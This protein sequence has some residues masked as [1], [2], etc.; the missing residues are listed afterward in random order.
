[1]LILC[2]LCCCSPTIDAQTGI[3]TD[4]VGYRPAD[5]K[6]AFV[7]GAH[8]ATFQVIG[9]GSD[10][11][12]YKGTMRPVGMTDESTG[13]YVFTLDFSELKAPGEYRILLPGQQLKS[14]VFRIGLDVYEPV[15]NAALESFYY[16]RCGMEVNNGTMWQHPGCHLKAAAFFENSSLQ[17]DVS[18]GW[19][20]AGDYGKYVATASLSAAF[21]LYAYE[22]QPGKF[23]DRQLKIPEAGNGV[24]DIL[25]EARW[26]LQWLLKMQDDKGGVYHKVSAKNWTGEHL[27]QDDQDVQYIFSVS[28]TATGSFAAVT[29]LGARV[30]AKWDKQFARSLLKASVAAWQF[31]DSHK[32]VVPPGGFRNPGGVEGG[33]Y[34]DQQDDDERLWASVEL[35]RTTSSDEYEKYFLANFQRLGGITYAVSW[36]QAQNFAYY[37]YLKL[38][39]GASDARAR[40][41]IISTLTSQCDN[42]LKRIEANGYRYVLKPDEYYWGSNSVSAG[43]AFDLI[44]AFEATNHTRYLNAALDQFHYLMGRNTFGLSFVTGIGTNPVR[45]PYH[46]FSMML[47]VANPVPGLLAG[48]ANM[49]SKLQGKVLSNYGGKCYEDNAKNY[50]VN[51]VAINYTAPLAF[52][53]SYVA[54]RR[55]PAANASK[56]IGKR[57]K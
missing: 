53:A 46:Q 22:L 24:P 49:S 33:E 55:P 4:Q 18:G 7:K 20:D 35:L 54:E 19:H 26:E 16:Q 40:S 27:P 45:H 29:A 6:I 28:S 37:S 14:D 39:A 57:S 48:G 1:M 43:Y 23:T 50:F 21:L 10:K 31:L 25:D 56:S 3:L 15:V 2:L 36:I 8:G 42:L 47:N 13:D 11:P 5:P 51:E 41:F 12:A 32:G 9:V 17:K 34:G 52:V 30:F 38:P 44:Q